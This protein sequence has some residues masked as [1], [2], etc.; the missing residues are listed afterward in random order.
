MA[1][2]SGWHGTN[3]HFEATL[4]PR[5]ERM[6]GWDLPTHCV[7]QDCVRVC[8]EGPNSNADMHNKANKSSGTQQTQ[9]PHTL[10]NAH[11]LDLRAP[12]ID[13]RV[14]CVGRSPRVPSTRIPRPLAPGLLPERLTRPLLDRRRN[15]KRFAGP[16]GGCH[17]PQGGK[18]ARTVPM[19][20]HCARRLSSVSIRSRR[21][22]T[23]GGFLALAPMLFAFCRV[24]TTRPP[25]SASNFP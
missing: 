6:P 1:D 14:T 24:H 22:Q 3:W 7:S 20:H 19:E 10:S 18:A 16:S 5:F 4:A 13:L 9:A 12:G 25:L 15:E 8:H 2:R 23:G 11:R 17:M 21:L